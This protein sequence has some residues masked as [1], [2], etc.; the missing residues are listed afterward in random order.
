MKRQLKQKHR[1]EKLIQVGLDEADTLAV[2]T[3]V[4]KEIELRKDPTIG[5]ATLLREYGMM[6][7]RRRL[8]ELV[9]PAVRATDDRRSG[10]ER[11]APAV[12]P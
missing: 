3:L 1:K 4:G 2:D 6:G 7:I 5:R 12:V 11:R 9:T 10:D 8:E